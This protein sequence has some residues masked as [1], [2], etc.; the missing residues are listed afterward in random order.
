[1]WLSFLVNWFVVF[2]CFAFKVLMVLCFGGLFG[3]IKCFVVCCF[4]VN[5]LLLSLIFA[6]YVVIL[7]LV[8]IG[9]Y[10]MF[11]ESSFVV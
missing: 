8:L 11:V 9:L 6:A 4:G 3:F 10:G 7:P 1:M 5:S 2:V